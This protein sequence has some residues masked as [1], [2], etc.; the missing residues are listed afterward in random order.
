VQL[1]LQVIKEVLLLLEQLQQRVALEAGLVV[2]IVFKMEL[3]VVQD[4]VV[5][6]Q[7]VLEEQLILQ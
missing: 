7:V 5:L 2:I 1:I 3:P 4:L 6:G